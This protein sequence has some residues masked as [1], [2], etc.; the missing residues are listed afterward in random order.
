MA[1]L[2]VADWSRPSGPGE[3]VAA[4][5]ACVTFAV[6]DAAGAGAAWLLVLARVLCLA[7]SDGS[8]LKLVAVASVAHANTSTPPL[9]C[10]DRT[11]VAPGTALCIPAGE[12]P[13]AASIDAHADASDGS[14][15]CVFIVLDIC[16][17]TFT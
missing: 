16:Y 12:T 5:L 4:T 2:G 7:D 6:D 3:G 11:Y 1:A 10:L 14:V 8:S 15:I 13:S 9:S 17:I